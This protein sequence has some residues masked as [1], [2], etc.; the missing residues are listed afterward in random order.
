AFW[1]APALVYR[2]GVAPAKSLF[3]SLLACWGNKGAMLVFIAGWAAVFMLTGLALS[4]IGSLFGGAQVLSV[5]V[6]PMVLIMASM[7]HTSLWFTF[8][9]SFRFDDAVLPPAAPGA[10]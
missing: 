8:R 6:Y 10:A 9:D 7:F 1:H 2:H 5:V 4:L 3:F